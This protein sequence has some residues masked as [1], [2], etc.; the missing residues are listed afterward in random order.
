MR[1]ESAST[2]LRWQGERRQG[3]GQ[4][5]KIKKVGLGSASRLLKKGAKISQRIIEKA[6]IGQQFIKKAGYDWPLGHQERGTRI[7]QWVIKD[8]PADHKEN[9]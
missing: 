8:H 4:Q 6:R 3:Q 2:S 7:S 9:G 1:L 5:G